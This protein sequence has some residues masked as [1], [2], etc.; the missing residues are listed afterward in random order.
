MPIWGADKG[1]LDGDSLTGAMF[2]DGIARG[3]I[4]QE[5]GEGVNVLVDWLGPGASSKPKRASRCR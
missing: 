4:S 2:G 1:R 3:T 5:K